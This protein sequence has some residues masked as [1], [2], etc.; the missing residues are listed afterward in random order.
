MAYVGEVFYVF[1]HEY[2]RMLGKDSVADALGEVSAKEFA[3]RALSVAKDRFAPLHSIV[4]VVDEY[5]AEEMHKI[6]SSCEGCKDFAMAVEG[7]LELYSAAVSAVNYRRGLRPVSFIPTRVAL[8]A[9]AYLEGKPVVGLNPHAEALLAQCRERK[10]VRDEDILNA[11]ERVKRDLGLHRVDNYRAYTIAGTLYDLVLLGL[12]NSRA[13][14]EVPWQ[15]ALLSRSELEA[16]CKA[17]GGG[18]LQGLETAAKFR[19]LLG[20]LADMWREAQALFRGP[21]LVDFLA[22]TAP[23]GLALL[24]LHGGGEL[25]LFLKRYLLMLRQSVLLRSALTFIYTRDSLAKDRLRGFI[26]RWVYP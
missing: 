16:A 25:E 22:A 4:R 7:V 15:P 24:N 21:E 23:A 12:C 20:A 10:E 19:P 3:P 18:T 14:K 8:S 13:F 17:L 6:A 5:H 1:K 9:E 2:L 26:E 11:F